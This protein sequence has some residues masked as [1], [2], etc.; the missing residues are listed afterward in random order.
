MKINTKIPA[1]VK[2]E[3]IKFDKEYCLNTL[4]T[5]AGGYVPDWNFINGE[6]DEYYPYHLAIDIAR[7]LI[8]NLTEE[9]FDAIY[10]RNVIRR[11]R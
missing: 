3:E 1:T 9:E 11:L 4:S 5:I 10:E 6:P 8:N 7:E 2:T